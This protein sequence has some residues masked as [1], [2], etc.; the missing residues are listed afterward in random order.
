MG[1]REVTQAPE[2]SSLGLFTFTLAEKVPSLESARNGEAT[3]SNRHTAPLPAGV[4]GRHRTQPS[5]LRF[6]FF[7]S[8]RSLRS[9]RCL[10]AYQSAGRKKEKGKTRKHYLHT[11]LTSSAEPE[12]CGLQHQQAEQHS[13]GQQD[14]INNE[15]TDVHT[16][17]DARVHSSTVAIQLSRTTR[18]CQSALLRLGSAAKAARKPGESGPF[19]LD[20]LLK[21]QREARATAPQP[22]SNASNS[23]MPVRRACLGL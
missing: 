7:D 16:H 6:F 12:H 21:V 22:T 18:R 4:G 11:R 14:E 10:T 23:I 3:E 1:L 2:L 9:F 20:K 13:Y 19:S 5:N 17:D 8:L 15:R